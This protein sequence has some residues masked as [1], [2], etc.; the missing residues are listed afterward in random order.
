VKSIQLHRHGE[1][2]S[3]PPER[4]FVHNMETH[5]TGTSATRTVKELIELSTECEC[6]AVK[7]HPSFERQ[8]ENVHAMTRLPEC[9]KDVSMD[10]KC[11]YMQRIMF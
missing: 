1:V 5:T 4:G 2:S 11:L 3:E 7:L 10:D 6:M 8:Y 9:L